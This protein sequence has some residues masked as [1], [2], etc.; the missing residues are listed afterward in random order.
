MQGPAARQTPPE[1]THSRLSLNSTAAPTPSATIASPGKLSKPKNSARRAQ[2]EAG[3]R[4]T[5]CCLRMPLHGST[6]IPVGQT[7]PWLVPRVGGWSP[8]TTR[9]GSAFGV[10]WRLLHGARA[11]APPQRARDFGRPRRRNPNLEAPLSARTGASELPRGDP[12]HGKRQGTAGIHFR[13]LAWVPGLRFRALPRLAGL[14]FRCC[15]GLRARPFGCRQGL[16]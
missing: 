12:S 14:L 1:S 4:F 8:N 16:R 2:R 10:E 9:P 3:P 11:S 7:R 6:L 13:V 5:L 15:Q